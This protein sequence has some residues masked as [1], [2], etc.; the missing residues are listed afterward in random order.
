[1]GASD[2]TSF[3]SGEDARKAFAGCVEQAQYDYGHAGYTGSIA[4]KAS[5]VVL[6]DNPQPL[7]TAQAIADRLFDD[8]DRRISDKWGPAGALRVK[9][10]Q[11][12][13]WL[14]FGFASS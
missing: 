9:D 8:D 12:D 1:M 5:F 14:F 13:G 2:F 11:N 10:D 6:D 7:E 3:G 4:E